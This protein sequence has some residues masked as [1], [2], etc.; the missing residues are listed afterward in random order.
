MQVSCIIYFG[1]VRFHLQEEADCQIRH[2]NFNKHKVYGASSS[3]HSSVWHTGY[4]CV[5]ISGNSIAARFAT[6][7]YEEVRTVQLRKLRATEVT[8]S[9]L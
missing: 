6:F 9:W 3:F 7:K 8:C 4:V 1:R 2:E 5:G